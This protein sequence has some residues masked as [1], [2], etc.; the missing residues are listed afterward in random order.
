MQNQLFHF[1]KKL[2][3]FF[4]TSWP[5]KTYNALIQIPFLKGLI[6]LVIR[7][8]TPD[9]VDIPEGRVIFDRDDP[10]MSGAIS[11]GKYEPETI[12]LFRSYLKEGMTV[13]DI[14]ANLGYFTV[15]AAGL[16]GP[17]GKVFSYEP[18]PH[19]FALLEKNVSVNGFKNVTNFPVALS[20]RRGTRELFF[21]DNQTTHSFSDKRGVGRS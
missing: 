1:A 4:P 15:I 19:N 12:A 5:F 18:D 7:R 13:V 21:G 11:F 10:V 16:V 9:Y 6:G 2:L 17:S 8:L 20:D 14:G 3:S